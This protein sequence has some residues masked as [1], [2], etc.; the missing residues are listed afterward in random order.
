[1]IKFIICNVTPVQ[2]LPVEY[3]GGSNNKSQHHQAIYCVVPGEEYYLENKAD[4]SALKEGERESECSAGEKVVFISL[5]FFRDQ[6]QFD[7]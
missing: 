4:N 7:D 3:S 6:N 1:M 5:Y 2:S